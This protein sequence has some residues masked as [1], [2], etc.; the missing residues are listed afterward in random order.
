MDPR[1]P[2]FS[3]LLTNRLSNLREFHRI[4]SFQ[5]MSEQLLKPILGRMANLVS[6]PNGWMAQ[7]G[8]ADLPCIADMLY[9]STAE[10][11]LLATHLPTQVKLFVKDTQ[12]DFLHFTQKYSKENSVHSALIQQQAQQRAFLS[13]AGQGHYLVRLYPKGNRRSIHWA[14]TSAVAPISW[15]F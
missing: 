8:A 6:G 5:E 3:D 10:T 15:L 11:L 14:R 7:T 1:L 12:R 2:A 13:A 9:Y 4:D